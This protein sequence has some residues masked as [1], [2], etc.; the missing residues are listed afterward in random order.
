MSKT[1]I[2]SLKALGA[3]DGIVKTGIRISKMQ[4]ALKKAKTYWLKIS[5]TMV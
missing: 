4:E 1:P 3:V 2:L 5:M